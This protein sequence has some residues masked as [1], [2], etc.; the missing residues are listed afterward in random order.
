M[1]TDLPRP[2][3]RPCSRPCPRIPYLPSLFMFM[4]V[5]EPR[6]CHANAHAHTLSCPAHALSCPAKAKCSKPRDSPV[7]ASCRLV[8]TLPSVV[9]PCHCSNRMVDGGC[10]VVLQIADCRFGNI[11]P[12]EPFDPFEPFK[13]LHGL[14]CGSY[15][16]VKHQL[17]V[18]IH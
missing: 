13:P 10:E 5:P 18:T 7:I 1:G 3:P 15:L 9:L 14:I 12:F 6:G 4:S 8:P 17:E 16:Y 11:E 2:R